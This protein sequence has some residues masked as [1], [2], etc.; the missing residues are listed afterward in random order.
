MLNGYIGQEDRLEALKATLRAYKN[1]RPLPN[2]LFL[3]NS[4]LGKTRLAE[5]VANETGRQL[6]VCHAPSV[7]DRADLTNK[8]IS[9]SGQILFIDEVHALNRMLAEDLYT[10]IDNHVVNV[11]T[12]L[13]DTK[14]K[15]IYALYK[16]QIPSNMKWHGPNSYRV[17]VRSK[18]VGTVQSEKKL[19][20]ITIIGAT[21]DEALLPPAFL[22]RLSEL[23]VYLRQYN[24]VE[25]ATIATLH[26]ESM[27]LVLSPEAAIYLSQRARNTPRRVKQLVERAADFAAPDATILE[28]HA[29]TAAEALGVDALGLEEPHR[30]ILR[31]L[32]ASPL[33]RTSLGQTLGLPAA[34]LSLYWGDLLAQGLVS[35]STRHELTAKGLQAIT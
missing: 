16:S 13:Y 25:L 30:A 11:E 31:A 19:T 2:M 6:V 32:R 10:V 18:K 14:Y 1:G 27:A 9:A 21:T 15:T 34:N 23:K 17:P 26:A 28:A 7:I 3:G 29:T 22:S 33:S 20:G 5:E 12:E 24:T 8:I 35:V 4:G